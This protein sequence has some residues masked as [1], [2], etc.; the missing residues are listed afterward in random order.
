MGDVQGKIFPGGIHPS[1]M[2]ESIFSMRYQACA[3]LASAWGHKPRVK[4]CLQGS[5]LEKTTT[6]ESLLLWNGCGE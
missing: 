3:A 4:P 6:P 5:Q 2:V 1:C